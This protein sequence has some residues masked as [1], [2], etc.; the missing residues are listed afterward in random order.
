MKDGD[1]PQPVILNA[2][3]SYILSLMPSMNKLFIQEA[4]V[5]GFDLVAI[6][7]AREVIF[8]HC[9]P[10]AKAYNGPQKSSE[11]EKSNH[12][13]ECLFNKM[14]DL[15]STSKMPIIACP[16][17][18][19]HMLPQRSAGVHVQ[20]NLQFERIDGEL[21]DLKAAFHRY[22]DIITS[23]QVPP[24][25]SLVEDSA[26]PASGIP[27]QVRERLNTASSS[28]RRKLTDDG[29]E[30]VSCEEFEDDAFEFPGHQ[31]RKMARATRNVHTTPTTQKTSYASAA[32][33]VPKK[34]EVVWGQKK[35]EAS[36]SFGG[37]KSVPR[38]PKIFISRCRNSTD[39]D[40]VKAFLINEDLDITDVEQVS[41]VSSKFK[42]FVV[43]VGSRDVFDKVL[44]G[45]HLPEYV[46]VRQYYPPRRD[47]GE[48]SNNRDVGSWHR[49]KLAE[50][51]ALSNIR[52]SSAVVTTGL[53]SQVLPVQNSEDMHT[54]TQDS[55]QSALDSAAALMTPSQQI[56]K[57]DKE[58]TD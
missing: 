10:K 28:K 27:A 31:R 14:K 16:A 17:E 43:S 13:F 53:S 33:T 22:T 42:S 20:C 18:D 6:K 41:H 4:T 5:S 35:N 58:T 23:K 50:L 49:S 48:Q 26:P 15:D 7:K 37:V 44:S 45:L 30:F 36:A 25:S 21:R 8:R 19:L 40:G 12:A 9:D 55:L 32:R 39:A 34:R 29:D 52:V 56:N 57:D 47:F 2:V 46:A 1:I 51:D 24:L 38:V 54:S 11:K 3:L